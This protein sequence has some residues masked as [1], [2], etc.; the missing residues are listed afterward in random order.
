MANK[1]LAAC[2]AALPRR[3]PEIR[4]VQ[5]RR[6]PISAEPRAELAAEKGAK[7]QSPKLIA[8][9]FATRRAARI[10][11][12]QILAARCYHRAANWADAI[13]DGLDP[14]IARFACDQAAAWQ[15]LSASYARCGLFT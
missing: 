9:R 8:E 14:D 2:A 4:I 13:R 1:A 11:D 3:A 6:P 15:L 7:P 10:A 5:Y 12:D